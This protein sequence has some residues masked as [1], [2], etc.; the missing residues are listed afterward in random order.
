MRWLELSALLCVFLVTT[1]T[2]FCGCITHVTSPGPIIVVAYE[3][4]SGDWPMVSR[5]TFM[6]DRTMMETTAVL[7]WRHNFSHQIGDSLY[8]SANNLSGQSRLIVTAR[9]GDYFSRSDECYELG[10]SA[11]VAFRI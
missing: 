11:I 3:V 2:V 9:S 8:L 10:D 1:A 7:P 4:K 6:V 5:I